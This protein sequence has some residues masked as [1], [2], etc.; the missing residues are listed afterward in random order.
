M[1]ASKAELYFD[2]E[3][4]DLAKAIDS[5]SP[6]A[7]SQALGNGAQVDKPGKSGVMPLAYAA[8]LPGAAS[9]IEILLGAGADP[10]SQD[11]SGHSPVTIA[12]LAAHPRDG[13]FDLGNITAVLEGGGDPNALFPNN[14]PALSR[15]IG[16]NNPALMTLLIEK[17]ADP[18]ARTRTDTPLII[19]AALGKY[20]D[21]VWV[22][23][24]GGADWRVVN[25]GSSMPATSD[26][27]GVGES[28]PSYADWKKVRAFLV[29]Q[30]I[31]LPAPRAKELGFKSGRITE[32]GFVPE[33]D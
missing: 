18:D 7:V 13:K 20:W 15:S 19:S 11:D 29:E 24:E 33:G 4:L 12:V 9:V 1:A 28:A 22:L 26:R 10:N 31:E 27:P 25:K 23:I 17:G 2:G 6:D 3:Q 14:D 21:A 5:L 30:D 16:Q 32:S 8:S